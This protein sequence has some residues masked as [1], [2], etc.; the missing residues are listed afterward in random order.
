MRYIC[1]GAWKGEANVLE[2]GRAK[3]LLAEGAQYLPAIICKN[4][5]AWKNKGAGIS[6]IQ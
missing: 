3:N 1:L 6:G 5:T 4:L 2:V